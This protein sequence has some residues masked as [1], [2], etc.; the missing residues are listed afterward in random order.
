MV[1]QEG[2][3]TAKRLKM[4]IFCIPSSPENARKYGISAQEWKGMVQRKYQRVSNS[5]LEDLDKALQIT[6]GSLV[7]A[8]KL[9][10]CEPWRA[11]NLIHHHKALRE[12]WGRKQRGRPA[13]RVNLQITPF[14]DDLAEAA[15]CGAE[16]AK[17][18][19]ARLSPRD[20]QALAEWFS[21]GG[22]TELGVRPTVV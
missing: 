4:Q 12:K 10:D 13:N 14:R 22:H 5:Q 2:A 6:G 17:G 11:K 15:W 7:A 20:R 18:L 1:I 3:N 8:A 21:K 19:I 9:I 16:F